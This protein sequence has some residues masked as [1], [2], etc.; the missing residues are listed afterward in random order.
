MHAYLD[1][2]SYYH[3]ASSQL[4][5]ST[6]FKCAC[7]YLSVKVNEQANVR[8]RDIINTFGMVLMPQ[9]DENSMVRVASLITLADYS[10]RR[11]Q[12][13]Y[14]EQQLIRVLNFDFSHYGHQAVGKMTQEAG[15]NIL[16]L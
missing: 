11:N 13:M 1:A 16:L 8:V 3:Y 4:G 15:D 9:T 6:D 14:F 5:T 7:I 12:V 10:E 2:S